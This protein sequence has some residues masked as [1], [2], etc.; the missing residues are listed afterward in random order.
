MQPTAP[1][2]HRVDVAAAPRDAFALFTSG[3]GEWWDPGVTTSFATSVDSTV[4]WR[5]M[6]QS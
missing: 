6:V 2:L 5:G 4:S 1:Y 3:M